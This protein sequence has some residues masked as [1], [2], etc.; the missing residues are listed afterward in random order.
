MVRF[1]DVS[2]SNNADGSTEL[3]YIILLTDK[4][5]KAKVLKFV[6]YKAKRI[7][8]SALLGETIAFSDAFDNSYALLQDLQKYWEKKVG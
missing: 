4:F 7:V 8:R 2:F 1:A 5:G 6:P 3:V